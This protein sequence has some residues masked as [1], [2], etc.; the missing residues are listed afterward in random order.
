[1]DRFVAFRIGEKALA[2]RMSDVLGVA[3]DLRQVRLPLGERGVVGICNWRGELCP[4]VDLGVFLGIQARRGPWA[5]I[6]QGKTGSVAVLADAIM[7]IEDGEIVSAEEPP[8]A[9]VYGE[10]RLVLDVK[11]LERLC[12]I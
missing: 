4:M 3:R 8:F 12:G 7:G 10:G 9:G 2:F 11:E 6:V 1:M 5:C